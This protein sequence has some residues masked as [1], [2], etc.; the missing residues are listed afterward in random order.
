MKWPEH[1]SVALKDIPAAIIKNNGLDLLD[2]YSYVYVKIAKGMYRLPQ[3][4]ILAKDYLGIHLKATGYVQSKHS[5]G[6][7]IHQT[8]PL[9]FCLVLENFAV[10]YVGEKHAQHLVNVLLQK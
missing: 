2:I 7:F 4:G 5:P 9:C 10:K 1:M 6:L 3:A 8:Q